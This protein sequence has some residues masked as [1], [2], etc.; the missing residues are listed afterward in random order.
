MPKYRI[1]F[2]TEVHSEAIIEAD[3]EREALRKFWSDDDYE[4]NDLDGE[5]FVNDLDIEVVA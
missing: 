4:V 2:W 5:T 3:S 1:P